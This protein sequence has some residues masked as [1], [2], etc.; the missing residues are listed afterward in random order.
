[1]ETNRWKQAEE[2]FHQALD[3]EPDSRVAYLADVDSDLRDEVPQLI[4]AYDAAE[5]CRLQTPA[6]GRPA[7]PKSA[8][9]I[10]PYTVIKEIGEGGMG[11]VYLAE[12][13]HAQYEKQ[14]AVKLIRPGPGSHALIHRF[15]VERQILAGM[16]HP[17][18]ARLIK[19][20]I[21]D[22]NQPF[23]EQPDA[24]KARI[25]ELRFLLSFTVDEFGEIVGLSKATVDRELK[26]IRG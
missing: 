19:G 22:E 15:H 5:A 4:Q 18:I 11:A 1:M 17:N 10:G 16:G 23:L 7:I 2:L 9:R 14:V 3:H 13:N 26:F 24:R 12:R 8:R 25:V 21:T 20:G 6:L